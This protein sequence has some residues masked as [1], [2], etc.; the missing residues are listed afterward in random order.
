M[1]LLAF[2]VVLGQVML[3]LAFGV[4]LGQ[5]VLLLAFGVVLGQVLLLAFDVVVRLCLE[6]LV[7]HFRPLSGWESFFRTHFPPG[8]SRLQPFVTVG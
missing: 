7:R 6:L 8:Y 1:L 3:L 2:G 5:V 4:V